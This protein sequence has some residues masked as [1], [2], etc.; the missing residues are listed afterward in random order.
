MESGRRSYER[1]RGRG[2]GKRRQ[3]SWRGTGVQAGTEV[4]VGRGRQGGRQVHLKGREG[5]MD[6]EFVDS[7]VLGGSR[8]TP[9]FREGDTKAHRERR[10]SQRT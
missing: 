8:R 6:R 10:A 3:D 5:V 9:P 2:G 7:E 1:K 4:D